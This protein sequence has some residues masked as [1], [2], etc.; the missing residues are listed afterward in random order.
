MFHQLLKRLL[1]CCMLTLTYCSGFGQF[2][3]SY[4]PEDISIKGKADSVVV[5]CFYFQ[6][7]DT[8]ASKTLLHKQTYTYNAKGQL[9]Q[10]QLA[11]YDNGAKPLKTVYVYNDKGYL[12]QVAGYPDKVLEFIKDN[13]TYNVAKRLVQIKSPEHLGSEMQLDGV[14]NVISHIDF[15]EYGGQALTRKFT[16]NRKNLCVKIQYIWPV[17]INN[18][19]AVFEYDGN[20]NLIRKVFYKGGDVLTEYIYSYPKVDKTGNWIVQNT[21][22]GGHLMTVTERTITYK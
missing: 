14:G 7:P 9:V 8:A 20:N 18:Q 5:A 11:E 6:K 13:Y 4:R 1:C 15:D 10:A 2:T 3:K 16:Y 21:Y 22:M 12:I 19:T 17:A